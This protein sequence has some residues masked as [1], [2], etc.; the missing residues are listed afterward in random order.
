VI[1]Q[2]QRSDTEN[3]PILNRWLSLGQYKNN[4]EQKLI[5]AAKR[6]DRVAFDR[7]IAQH[8]TQLRGFVARRINPNVVDDIVQDIWIASWDSIRSFAGRSRFKAW[9]YQIAVHK[10]ADY[11]RARWIPTLPIHEPTVESM[12]PNTSFEA[13]SNNRHDVSQA[14]ILLPDQQR[15]VLELYYWADL[16]LA[17]IATALDRNLNTVKY[18]FYKAHTSIS[19]LLDD[20]K[21]VVPYASEST[22]NGKV[23]T[24]G[25]LA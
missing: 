7:L 3:L 20:E 6:G 24:A 4:S 18:H 2:A 12:L 1:L 23:N 5:D 9:L 16:T 10:C 15:E 14:L 19:E 21:Q 11:Q 25:R 22:H 17:E 13:N 8:E